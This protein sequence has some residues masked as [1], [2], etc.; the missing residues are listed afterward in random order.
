M[1]MAK[2]DGSLLLSLNRRV[3]DLPARDSHARPLA[4]ESANQRMEPTGLKVLPSR[5][6]RCA[7]GSCARR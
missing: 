2:L 5:V 7:G 4:A 3:P 1:A 6:R